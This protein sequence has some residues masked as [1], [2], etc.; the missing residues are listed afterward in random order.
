MRYL[1]IPVGSEFRVADIKHKRWADDGYY[2]TLTDAQ[3]ALNAL[4]DIQ[5]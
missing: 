3:H 5:P 2:Q 1:V 4:V